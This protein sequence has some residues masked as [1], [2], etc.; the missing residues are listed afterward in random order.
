MYIQNQD[1]HKTWLKL[2]TVQQPDTLADR[3]IDDIKMGNFW[4]S[5]CEVDPKF[6]KIRK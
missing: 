4:K 6:P 1:K 5:F 3:K 2:S